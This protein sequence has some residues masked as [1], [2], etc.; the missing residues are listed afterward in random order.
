MEITIGQFAKLVG[1]TVRTLRYYDKIGLLSP[2]KFNT[3]GRKI[4][5]HVDFDSFQQIMILKDFDL[6]LY[7]I[8]EHLT[9]EKMNKR[10]LLQVQK[11]LIEQKQAELNDMLEVITRMDRLY[12]IEGT[13]EEELNEFAF[14]ML[15]LFRR[16]KKQIQAFEK[17]FVGNAQFLQDLKM[18]HDPEY[19]EKMDVEVWHLLQA[20]KHAMQHNDAASRKKVRDILN[21]MD[22][23]FPASRNFLTLLEDDSFFESYND[24]FSNYIP[25]DI[26]RYILK[27]MRTY[28]AD[29][30]KR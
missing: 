5:T 25:E 4:Y 6:S 26:A 22:N 7:E 12:T 28:Y 11:K 23:L 20:I 3:S 17:H 14:I 9:N 24:E 13:S 18:L 2:Q 30:E 8:K 16:E 29:H 27:E 10:D 19:K 1:S 21:E 15:D